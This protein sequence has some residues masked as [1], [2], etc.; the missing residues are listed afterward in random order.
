MLDLQIFAGGHSVTVVAGENITAASAS[1]TTDVQ[2]DAEVTLTITP[3]SGY[4]A[5]IQVVSGGVEVDPETLKFT[6]GEANVVIAV[7]AKSANL[8]RVTEECVVN[9]NGTRMPL[10]RN[11]KLMYSANGQIS[12]AVTEPVTLTNAGHIEALLNAGLIEK[13]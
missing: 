8:Y 4:E 7:T 10:H 2:K 1:E 5:Q 12:E 9:V 3:A 11:V 13:I 6:M